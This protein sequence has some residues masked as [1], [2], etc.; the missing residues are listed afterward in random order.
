MGTETEGTLYTVGVGINSPYG[1]NGKYSW[2]TSYANT[3]GIPLPTAGRY[4]SY[5][6][7]D[8][9]LNL[10]RNGFGSELRA[11]QALIRSGNLAQ[12]LLGKYEALGKLVEAENA[13]WR[14]AFARQ[15]IQV[16]KDVLARADRLLQWAKRRVGLQLGDRGD[17]LQ[18]QAAFDLHSLDLMASL[19]EEKA[20]A[21][22]FNVLRKQEGESVPEAVALPSIEETLKMQAPRRDGDR[23]D[24]QAAEERTKATQAQAQLDKETLKPSV[25]ITALYAWNGRDP[26]RSEAISSAFGSTHPTKSI[27][28]AF[29]VPLNVPTW[30]GAIRGANQGIEQAAY[31]LEQ[32]RLAEARD[33]RDLS[34]RLATARARLALTKTVEEVQREKFENER[35]R[36]QRG[37]TTS[38][39]ALTFEQ[40]YA[41]AQLLRLRTQAEVLQ[42]LAQMKTYR[43][44]P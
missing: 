6:R 43:G 24:L 28:V 14:L 23:L 39:Q 26:L 19:E 35:Q 33:W 44:N 1:L 11:H 30:T 10:A 12:G 20:A 40:D 16:H 36:L 25:D 41:Q 42:L 34:A 17:L 21:R 9:T 37:R 29:S 32:A 18:A 4:T 8:L 15:T 5:N 2:N 27:A 13:Y 7:L 38:F 3:V 31:E 22:A